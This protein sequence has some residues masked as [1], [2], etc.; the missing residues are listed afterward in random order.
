MEVVGYILDI[1]WISNKL[2]KF[3]IAAALLSGKS[4]TR[5]AHVND[6]GKKVSIGK[7]R[8]TFHRKYKKDGK[9]QEKCS[10]LII[11][12][13]DGTTGIGKESA[14]WVV[15]GHARSL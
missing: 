13:M 6:Q 3:H 14:G 5:H 11:E 1:Y 9:G 7:V 8:E 15:S 2:S 10:S 12:T 4:F